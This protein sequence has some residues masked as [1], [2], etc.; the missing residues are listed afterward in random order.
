MYDNMLHPTRTR[1]DYYSLDAGRARAS[2]LARNSVAFAPGLTAENN[3]TLGQLNT[4]TKSAASTSSGDI[5][6]LVLLHRLP[7]N[8]KYVAAPVAVRPHPPRSLSHPA[9]T[10]PTRFFKPTRSLRS[11]PRQRLRQILRQSCAPIKFPFKL[12][13]ITARR[14]RVIFGA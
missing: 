13:V 5:V 10:P 6:G 4:K 14:V 7:G 11:L 12:L 8:R 1:A 9:H 2:Y 3:T